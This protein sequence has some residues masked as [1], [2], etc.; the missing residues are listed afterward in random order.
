MFVCPW[1]RG[2]DAWH[3]QGWEQPPCLN[4]QMAKVDLSKRADA[5]YLATGACVAGGPGG[6]GR[7]SRSGRTSPR[8]YRAFH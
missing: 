8:R 1:S 2:G 6:G 7:W 5:F 3:P 4:S